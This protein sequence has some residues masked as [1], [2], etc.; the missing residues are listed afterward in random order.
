MAV[1]SQQ[2]THLHT[3]AASS[4]LVIALS[5]CTLQI[6]LSPRETC[7]VHATKKTVGFVQHCTPLQKEIPRAGITDRRYFYHENSSSRGGTYACIIRS[8]SSGKRRFFPRSRA[9]ASVRSF[10]AS[11]ERTDK[12]RISGPAMWIDRIVASCGYGCRH[13]SSS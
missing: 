8:A 1:T 13:H 4:F 3:T 5:V 7:D 2:R 10:G 12:R 9:R 6:T 11:W